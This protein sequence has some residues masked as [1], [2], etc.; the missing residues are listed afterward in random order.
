MK[1]ELDSPGWTREVK[2]TVDFWFKSM[3]FCIF[4]A[5]WNPERT[6]ASAESFPGPSVQR[7]GVTE[8]P[9]LPLAELILFG[10]LSFE[11]LTS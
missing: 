11:S 9:K 3:S 1:E 5:I 10:L 8:E 7:K 4:A 6:E 2:N